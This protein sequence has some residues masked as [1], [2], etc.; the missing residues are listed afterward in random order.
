VHDVVA[1]GIPANWTCDC[2]YFKHAHALGSLMG[3]HK[4]F[5]IIVVIIF[6]EG[7]CV[8]FSIHTAMSGMAPRCAT[9]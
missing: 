6:M 9:A 5:I 2:S 8:W 1:L 4:I 3:T 7:C